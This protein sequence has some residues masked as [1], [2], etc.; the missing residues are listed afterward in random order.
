MECHPEQAHLGGAA[1]IDYSVAKVHD[2][3]LCESI[4]VVPP[5]HTCPVDDIQPSG[6]CRLDPD[7]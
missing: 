4:V 7:G 1:E 3:R 6:A 2:G 5:D